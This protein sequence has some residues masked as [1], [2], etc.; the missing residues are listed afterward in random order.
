ML[1]QVQLQSGKSE[2]VVKILDTTDVC[3]LL[4]IAQKGTVVYRSLR[5][6]E[7][8]Q[9]HWDLCSDLQKQ[10]CSCLQ[11][12]KALFKVTDAS[13]L[14]LSRHYCLSTTNRSLHFIH[15]SPAAQWET[16]RLTDFPIA[17]T[18][19][20]NNFQPSN[21][22]KTCE[23]F[24]GDHKGNICVLKFFYPRTLLFARTY[25]LGTQVISF[26]VRM[27]ML[28]RTRIRYRYSFKRYSRPLRY[29]GDSMGT[30][31][32]FGDKAKLASFLPT[33]TSNRVLTHRSQTTNSSRVSL[34]CSHE[35]RT[36]SIPLKPSCLAP[37]TFSFHI[38]QSG[39]TA[40]SRPIN[41]RAQIQQYGTEER[42]AFQFPADVQLRR[43]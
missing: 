31:R 9:F 18:C 28:F 13:Y 5:L 12:R 40:Q 2:K 36:F 16:F 22:T 34:V 33:K 35:L 43:R 23:L 42:F 25:S 8:A 17:P 27:K 38:H 1:K 14:N 21:K 37:P 6:Q 26:Q 10:N 11:S 24:I 30:W 20:E 39:H 19:L 15:A 41:V 3:S 4:F 32:N 29:D 7:E